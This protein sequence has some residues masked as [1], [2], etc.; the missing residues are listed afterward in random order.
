MVAGKFTIQY[1][2]A[3]PV[4]IVAGDFVSELPGKQVVYHSIILS[5]YDHATTALHKLF[6]FQL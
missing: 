1:E 5:Q 4:T 6:V 2:G 3:E